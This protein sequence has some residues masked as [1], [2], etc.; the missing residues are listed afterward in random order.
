MDGT[1]QL[2]S[3][4]PW[5]LVYGNE[6]YCEVPRTVHYVAESCGTKVGFGWLRVSEIWKP[7]IRFQSFF[8]SGELY[9]NQLEL[10]S[11]VENCGIPKFEVDPF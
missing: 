10:M 3:Q 1:F 6:L 5:T 9:G 7:H 2:P 8:F 4:E 11:L